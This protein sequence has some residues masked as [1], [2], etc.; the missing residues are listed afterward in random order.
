MK[1][2]L[3][4]A[5]LVSVFGADAGANTGIFFGSGHTITLG[6][7]EQAELV[8]EDVTI[9]P[10]C[11]WHTML[12]SVDYRCKFVLKNL[13]AKPVKIQVGFPL[14]GQ[15]VAGAGEVPDT[16]DLVLDYGFIARDEKDTYHVRFVSN[17]SEKKFSRLFL[18]DMAFDP[19]ETKVL[20][21]AYHLP[22]SQG[23]SSTRKSK[24]GLPRYEQAWHKTL[25]MC[26]V[27]RF[28]YITE[29]GKAWTGP[30]ESATFRVMTGEW[31]YFWQKR[32]LLVTVQP[33]PES[34]QMKWAEYFLMAGATYRG[35]EP[36]G[37]Q[38]DD[39]TGTMTWQYRPYKPGAPLRFSCNVVAI[40]RTAADCKSWVRLI[41][42][43]KPSKA[44]LAE[45][46]EI[47][48]AFYGIAP[49]SASAKQF[50]EQQIWYH[51]KDGLREAKLNAE[52]R[53]VLARLDSIAKENAKLQ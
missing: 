31:E 7:S 36:D 19:A 35:V 5:F 24:E 39:R 48:A 41:L 43:S 42:G 26:Y 16:T 27:E 46:R 49:K 3:A 8:S 51:P 12:D 47:V 17:D 10:K 4:A 40:P 33:E 18:W 53:A 50:V 14:D 9:T 34:D 20:R 38:Y 22:M 2:I 30:I 13:T 15:V 45:L 1:A 23:L 52:Q 29:T 6:K 37:C 11:G 44:D 32:P 25:E 28:S 21:V